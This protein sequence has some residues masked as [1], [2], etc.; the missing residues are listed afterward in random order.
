MIFE[1]SLEGKTVRTGDI[2]ATADG[3]EGSFSGAVFKLIGVMIPG[4]P[5]HIA[6]YLGP[7]GICIEAGPK[8]VS[9]FRFLGGKWEAHRMERQRGIVDKLH[10]VGSLIPN[11]APASFDE[12]A[13][14]E[15]VRTFLLE[16]AGKPYNWDFLNPDQ[17]EAFYCSQLAYAAYKRIGVNLNTP[18]P[19]NLHPLL[20]RPIVT[21]EEVWN[22][23]PHI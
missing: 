21:P 11:A 17:E 2:I 8:D 9:L 19:R 7:D 13:A 1:E 14:R 3:G 5:D 16:Q 10:G 15:T 22:S 6:L 23:V 12:G 20:P 18:P 4:R